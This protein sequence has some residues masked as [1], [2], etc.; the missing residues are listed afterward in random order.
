ML[1][2]GDLDNSFGDQ[3]R[4]R[5]DFGIFNPPT[6]PTYGAYFTG[7]SAQG[8]TI[9]PDGRIVAV[10]YVSYGRTRRDF[11]IARVFGDPVL[12]VGAGDAPPPAEPPASDISDTEPGP[13]H[14]GDPSEEP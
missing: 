5:I 2:N 1:N 13:D 8:V 6:A 7:D 14:A 3:V 10:G 4:V 11:G 9:Q 12:A